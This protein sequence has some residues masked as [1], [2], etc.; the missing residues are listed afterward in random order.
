MLKIRLHEYCLENTLGDIRNC[1]ESAIKSNS[2]NQK[3]E[4]IRQALGAV[5]ALFYVLEVIE[6]DV[7]IEAEEET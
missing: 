7:D 3:N 1:L 2:K 5:E 6:T 4:K